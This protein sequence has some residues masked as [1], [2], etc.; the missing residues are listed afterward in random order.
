MLLLKIYLEIITNL[1][2]FLPVV[3]MIFILFK[4][5]F[6]LCFVSYLQNMFIVGVLEKTKLLG[7]FMT[8]RGCNHRLPFYF[9]S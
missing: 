8:H 7:V 1:T 6:I 2:F 9:S 4:I 5:N 3:T